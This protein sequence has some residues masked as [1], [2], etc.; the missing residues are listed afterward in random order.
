MPDII[1]DAKELIQE[2]VIPA[3][4]QGHDVESFYPAMGWLCGKL[5]DGQIPLITGFESLPSVTSDNLKAFCA[6]FGT[7]G[8]SPVFHMAHVTPEAMQ[9][10][11][12]NLL[13]SCNRRVLATKQDLCLAYQTL[14]GGSDESDNRVHLVALGNPHLSVTE[15]RHISEIIRS[16]VRPKHQDVE[17]IATLGRHVYEEGR[18]LN[19]IQDMETF[20][21]RFVNDTC[22]CM[23]LHPP[24]I[25]HSKDASIL[26]NSSKY[27]TYGPG[28]VN[29][30][31]RFSSIYG[32][33]EASKTGTI[34]QHCG[35]PK[36]LRSFSTM[37]RHFPK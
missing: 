8:T 26:T 34:S 37:V 24:I 5:S 30:T 28:L 32:C 27:A 2:D 36:W 11:I 33:I 16:D 23:L 14:D 9:D 15:L 22:W 4:E 25:P 6:A 35:V 7:T 29:R 18:K 21:V 12:D 10:T 31:L 1:I 19:Y 3:I 17:V 13:I 20:G